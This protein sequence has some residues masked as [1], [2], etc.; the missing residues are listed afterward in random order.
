MTLNIS[1]QQARFCV[2][3]ESLYAISDGF[4]AG[5]GT[6][7]MHATIYSALAGVVQVT[8]TS[9]AS[10]DDQRVVSVSG[11]FDEKKYVLPTNGGIVTARVES[12]CLRYAKC[13]IICIGHTHLMDEFSATLRK[14]DARELDKDNVELYKCVQPGD[15]ILARVIGV[16]D[17]QTSFLL[18][19]AENEL[20]VTFAIGQNGEKMVPD[21]LAA[22]KDRNSEY[23]EPRKVARVPDLNN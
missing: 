9:Q 3:G 15:L 7:E 13:S 1:R 21:T 19:I 16:G 12:L 10:G 8:T 6:Y 4:I 20:G 23:R 22:V 2:P 11:R 17:T 14:E 5:F 18:S